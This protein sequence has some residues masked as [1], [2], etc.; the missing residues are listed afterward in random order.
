MG[1]PT[2]RPKIAWGA[3]LLP[4][5]LATTAQA[6]TAQANTDRWSGV[7]VTPTADDGLAVI[8][9][10]FDGVEVLGP[11][12]VPYFTL[13]GA[14]YELQDAM[15]VAGPTATRGPGVYQVS[16]TYRVPTAQGDVDV[17]VSHNF[18]DSDA[19]WADLGQVGSWVDF[20]GPEGEYTFY[21]R[22]DV[23]AAGAGNDR[24]Q[25]FDQQRQ[26]RTL[27]RTPGEEVAV[28][29]GGT[30]SW[31]DRIQLKVMDGP[32][33]AELT[34]LYLASTDAEARVYAVR[35]APGE[36]EAFPQSLVNGQRLQQL[37]SDG[38][39]DL[40][41]AGEDVVL[42]YSSTA[43]GH[44]G[45]LGPQFL[46]SAAA[47]RAGFLEIDVMRFQQGPPA[48]AVIDGGNQ[49]IA[50]AFAT[51]SVNLSRVDD[52]TLAYDSRSSYAEIQTILNEGKSFSSQESPTNW[53]VHHAVVNQLQGILGF[54][55]LGVMHDVTGYDTNG[56]FREGST[57]F[58][59]PLSKN[60]PCDAAAPNDCGT[61]LLWTV[62][63]ETGHAFNLHH[64]DW[65]F[66]TDPASDFFENSA[67]MGYSYDI[68]T[69][70][71]S[72]GPDNGNLH[73]ANHPDEYVRP[74]Y[75]VDFIATVPIPYPY[76]TWGNHADHHDPT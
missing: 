19:Q 33:Y 63:H 49:T 41:G 56:I 73:L 10:T 75:G 58:F 61:A 26:G 68:G 62:A 21:W 31:L 15:R 42:W 55:V 60:Y 6:T 65:D 5:L 47:A 11:M 9:A 18:T 54:A 29:L 72:F 45:F 4:C 23:D 16:A 24:V 57:S 2:S 66:A 35:S 48:T 13:N 43:R 53:Y 20:S 38:N 3:L 14:R 1:V 51:G 70:H 44:S 71:W 40:P 22:V 52:E 74:G 27:F 67:I 39:L 32:S 12:A 17:V 59:K 30:S 8:G 46:V 76:N 69:L 7:Q 36:G 37:V 25:V 28:D 34:S 64:E 50:S